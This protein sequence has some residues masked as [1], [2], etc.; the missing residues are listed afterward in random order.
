VGDVVVAGRDELESN[1]RFVSREK[2]VIANRVGQMCADRETSGGLDLEVALL[3]IA[4]SSID[5]EIARRQ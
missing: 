4:A 3:R 5:V 1:A 2:L